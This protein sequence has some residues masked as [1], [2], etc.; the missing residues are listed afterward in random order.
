MTKK[1]LGIGNAIVD[2]ACKI[3]DDFLLD[4]SLIKGS[5]SLIDEKTA[6][7]LS[8]LE[9]EKTT[10][11]GSAGN[12]IATMSQL[13]SETYF[14][15]KVG[16]DD[17]GAQF[18]SELEKSGTR[19]VGG[20]SYNKLSAKSFIL[21]TPDAERTMCTFLGCASEIS[22]DLIKDEL[23][24]EIDFLYLEGYLWDQGQTILA[25]KKAIDCAKNNGAKIAFSLSDGF[26]VS[27]H[28]NDFIDLIADKI[29][30][31]FANEDEA[32]ELSSSKNFTDKKLEEFFSSQKHLTTIVTRAEKG[33]VVF[34]NGR[35]LEV[36]TPTIAEVIDTTGAGDAFAAGFLKGFS[37][38]NELQDCAEFGNKLAG[39][40][41]QKFG[42]RFEN[43]EVE[44]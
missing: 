31:L 18:I 35:V 39:K 30:V 28:K 11:G 13:G 21:V 42:A 37:N 38:G 22:E 24:K 41:I 34:Q 6:K 9:S 4:N 10:S 43:E 2:I 20:H 26:C 14:I 27:R 25:L 33:C 23:F 15:G 44:S 32:I 40:I 5:M 3:N 12:T 1:I 16:Q 36:S 8:E 29:D 7:K 19:F 17:F